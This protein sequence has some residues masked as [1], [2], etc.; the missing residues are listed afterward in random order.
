MKLKLESGECEISPVNYWHYE[1]AFCTDRI[2][3]IGV[4]IVRDADDEAQSRLADEIHE[5]L[6]KMF[7]VYQ[8]NKQTFEVIAFPTE[9]EEPK[10]LFITCHD[11]IVFIGTGVRPYRGAVMPAPDKTFRCD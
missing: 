9:A 6:V 5:G 4:H 11:N 7:G 2:A 1:R 8:D 10:R 3:Q